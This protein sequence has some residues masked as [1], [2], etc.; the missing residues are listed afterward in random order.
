MSVQ[1]IVG[2][3]LERLLAAHFHGREDETVGTLL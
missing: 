2:D 1:I 3:A